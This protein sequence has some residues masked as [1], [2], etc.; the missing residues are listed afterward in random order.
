VASN[1]SPAE[2]AE[3]KRLSAEWRPG[4]R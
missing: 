1:M 3:A 2:I 4:K